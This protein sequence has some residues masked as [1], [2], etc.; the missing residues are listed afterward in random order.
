MLKPVKNLDNIGSAL[1]IPLLKLFA[2]KELYISLID[3][4]RLQ[5]PFCLLVRKLIDLFDP[6]KVQGW[7]QVCPSQTYL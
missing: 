3:L 4:Q 2:C 1:R 6:L 5:R 7:V